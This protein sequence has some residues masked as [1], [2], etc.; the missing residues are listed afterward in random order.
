MNTKYLVRLTDQERDELATVI[1]RFKGTSEKVRRVQIL[2]KADT[3]GPNW[4]DK[5]IVE[6]L[7]CRRQPVENVR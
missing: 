7:G 1:K 5:R 6:A 2:L 4:V 3:D